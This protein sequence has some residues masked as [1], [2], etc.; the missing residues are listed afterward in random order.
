MEG[1]PIDTIIS[2]V[3]ALRDAH[4]DRFD[5]DVGAIFRDI[6]AIQRKSGLNHIRHPG[7]PLVSCFS[8]NYLSGDGV[9]APVID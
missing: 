7:R 4:A 2:E 6:R 5:Y 8:R 9:H 1:H 3:R